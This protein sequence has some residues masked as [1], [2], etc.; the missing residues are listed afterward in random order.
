MA[1]QFSITQVSHKWGKSLKETISSFIG[2][3]L[4]YAEIDL[5]KAYFTF[6]KGKN[7]ILINDFIPITYTGTQ[8]HLLPIDDNLLRQIRE[9][10]SI[11]VDS[12][13]CSYDLL[14]TIDKTLFDNIE[15]ELELCSEASPKDIEVFI[16]DILIPL[17][18]TTIY[19]TG[20]NLTKHEKQMFIEQKK[21]SVRKET[22]YLNTIGALLDIILSKDV[23][24]TFSSQETL[25][26]Y[27]DETYNQ[28]EDK[29][30]SKRTLD[31]TFPDARKSLES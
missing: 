19:I 23:N 24:E 6:Y 8:K 21:P 5:T 16:Q 20:R 30:L 26:I 7:Q 12:F 29:G 25:K 27:I 14:K 1:K 22:T 17:E 2:K 31:D 3:D 10:Y 18:P 15:Y 11:Q 4:I 28:E 13:E 9:N